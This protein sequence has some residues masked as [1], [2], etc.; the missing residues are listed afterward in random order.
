[1]HRTIEVDTTRGIQVQDVTSRLEAEVPAD[2]TGLCLL[3]CRHTTAGLTVNE[4]EPGLLEDFETFLA[5]VVPDR[6]WRHDRIDDNAE[7]H[8]QSVL[9]GPSVTVPVAGGAFDLG[10]WQSILLVECDGPRTRRI[11]VRS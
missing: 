9:V 6:D 11:E 5:E 7:S 3:T 2:T 1:M 8:L 4:A 10:T